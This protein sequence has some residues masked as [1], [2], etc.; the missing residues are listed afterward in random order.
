MLFTPRSPPEEIVE[1]A[2][3]KKF[4]MPKAK[5]TSTPPSERTDPLG[6]KGINATKTIQSTTTEKPAREVKNAKP[7][8]KAKRDCQAG[9]Y[10]VLVCLAD[11]DDPNIQRLISIPTDAT[12]HKLHQAIQI[13]FGWARCHMHQFTVMEQHERQPLM[14]RSLLTLMAEPDESLIDPEEGGR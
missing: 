10:L 5:K 2:T 6:N 1:T 11:T 9:N 8:T 3:T 12:F 4:K 13:S 7:T 14:G